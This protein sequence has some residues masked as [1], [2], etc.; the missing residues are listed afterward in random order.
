MPQQLLP[1]SFLDNTTHLYLP[2]VQAQAMLLYGL[3]L[4]A[5]VG[6]AIAAFFIKI[7]VSFAASGLLRSVAEKTE[8]RPLV[9]GRVLRAKA[10]EN[11][12]VQVGDTLLTL[13][14]DDLNERLRLCRHLQAERQ[15]LL[16]DL[17]FLTSP[18]QDISEALGN[19]AFR[20]SL[21]AQQY[22]ELQARLQENEV[23][24]NKVE[25][26]FKADTYLFNEKV[27]ATREFD[28]KKAETD[29]LY[30][31]YRLLIERQVSQW[32]ADLSS[33]RFGLSELQAQE[34]QL[35]R[36]R[37]LYVLRAPVSGNVQ[38]WAGK[39]EGSLVQSGEALGIISPDSSLL[40]ETYVRPADMGL[41]KLDQS[42]LLQIDA[43]NYREWGLARGKVMDIANDFVLMNEQPVFKVKCRL[44]TPKLKLPNGYQA[45]LQKGMT[46]QARFV[47]VRRTLAQLVF[48][49]MDD[50]LNPNSPP[51]PDGGVNEK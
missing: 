12:P 16:A 29:Q 6:A 5:V 33:Q 50:W 11:A 38:Q 3:V 34:Q 22:N 1:D 43:L 28:A 47:V 36:E 8:I 4:A 48:D 32:E 26:E 27:I 49:K 30:E 35:L 25:K 44:E 41:L 2:Q 14:P 51:T 9:S 46:L 18:Q 42:V 40:V 19:K 7:D 39:Y 13:A 45:R 21:Y 37:E 20:S 31:E 17:R 23:R 10:R 15:Q 24:R